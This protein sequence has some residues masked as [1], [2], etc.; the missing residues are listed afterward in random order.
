[1]LPALRWTREDVSDALKQGLGRTTSDSGGKRTRGVL[2]VAEVALSLMLLIGAGL[3]IRSLWALRNVNP[4]FDPDHV[5]TMDLS[6][7]KNKFATPQQQV[8]YFNRVL[9]RVRALPGVQSAGLIDALPLSGSG[10]HQPIQVEGKPVVPMADQPEVDVRLISPGYVEAM[11]VPLLRGRELNESDVVGRPGTVIISQSMA[12]MLWPNED[13]IGKHLTLYFFPE[14]SREVV[15]VAGD[16]KLDALNQ[17]RPTATLYMPLEQLSAPASG[18]WHSFGLTLAV[19]TRT[20]PLGAVSAI[21]NAIHEVD[22]EVPLLNTKTMEVTVDES[23][24]Q[25][26]FTMLLLVAFAALAVLLAAIGIYSVLS[27]AVRRRVREIGIRMAL[28]AQI[29]D[30]LRMVL[31]EGMKP[32]LLGVAFGVAGALALGKVLSSVIYGVSARDLATF[33]T[34]AVGMILVGL[35]AST[36]PAYRATRVDPMKTLREE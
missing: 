17:T 16:V 32:T 4:G 31:I 35:L 28:G 8:S 33:A 12:Q 30:V 13:P 29:R 36:V 34:V 5:V 24:S 7:P 19:R 10:S 23:L 3:L 27:Y 25:Q 20:A 14:M 11:H 1:V 6:I 21:G 18:G 9:D 26:R 15:G 2:V 22:P